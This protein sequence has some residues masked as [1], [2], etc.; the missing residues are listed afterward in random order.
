MKT[1]DRLLIACALTIALITHSAI[2][3]EGRLTCGDPKAAGKVKIQL[4]GK[5]KDGKRPVLKEIPVDIPDPCT[6][7]EKAKEIFETLKLKGVKVEMEGDTGMKLLEL[8]SDVDAIGFDPDTTSEGFDKLIVKTMAS[9]TM[10][11]TGSFDP[12]DPNGESATFTAGLITDVGELTATVTADELNF[13]TDGPIICQALFQRLQPR[14]PEY[15]AQIN[16]AGDRLEVYFDPA[17]TLNQGGITFG[18]TSPTAGCDGVGVLPPGIIFVDPAA[19][20]DQS[21]FSWDNAFLT[22]RDALNALPNLP[23]VAECW[24]AGGVYTPSASGDRTAAFALA[25]GVAIYGGFDG[26]ESDR[27]ERDP[28]ENPTI[29]SGDLDGDDL[30]DFVN[31]AENSYH[32]VTATNVDATALLD[33][34]TITGGNAD[35]DSDGQTYFY[36][37]GGAIRIDHASP[38][39]QNCGV[40]HNR[41]KFGGGVECFFAT[42]VLTDIRLESNL[43]L[44]EG[45]GLH[46]NRSALTIE[47]GTFRANTALG[48]GG[49][50][51]L[52]KGKGSYSSCVFEDNS[53]S[54][55]GA[56][57][58]DNES[59][60]TFMN[61]RA[62]GNRAEHNGGA[63]LIDRNST[64]LFAGALLD[65]NSAGGSGGCIRILGSGSGLQLINGTL[66]ANRAATDGGISQD[67]GSASLSNCILWYNED[68]GG[69]T[70]Q[71]QY[72]KNAG[73]VSMT[74][75]FVQNWSGSYGGVGNSGVEPRLVAAP[76]WDGEVFFPGDAHPRDDSPVRDAGDTGALPAGYDHDLDGNDRV[77][78]GHVD[79]G[80]YELRRRPGRP[81]DANCDGV[82]DFNDIDCFVAALISIEAWIDC[83]GVQGCDY[84]YV[85]DING[86]GKV[87]FND[88]DGFVDCLISGC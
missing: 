1:F 51:R 52:V 68:T 54:S 53:A 8:N 66:V 80:G 2:A 20:G 5:E 38:T 56:M 50:C 13:Q 45:G 10:K 37:A 35:G 25:D 63:I 4:L 49:G 62:R 58:I 6:D 72:N 65:G 9:G 77:I 86:D 17:Y 33:G 47:R 79:V 3:R 24:V 83:G 31:C 44:N 74:D 88:I 82:V 60:P 67:D 85:N 42:A 46:N 22:L 7:K 18:T 19:T 41:A 27:A 14:A 61:T 73:A 84:I 69:M 34:F 29:L 78:D 59:T 48:S 70:E 28:S 57:L 87:D 36:D 26:T 55:G 21:G 23:S 64:P 39:I 76:Y 40:S 12:L 11:F 16:Y 30:P 32:I 75:C 43:A 71:S 15:G 81:G